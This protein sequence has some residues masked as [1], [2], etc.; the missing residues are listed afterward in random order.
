MPLFTPSFR[1]LAL[2]LFISYFSLLL[3]Q[4]EE[5]KVEILSLCC[6]LS[7]NFQGTIA[8]EIMGQVN[9]S[10]PPLFSSFWVPS[11]HRLTLSLNYKRKM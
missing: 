6:Y 7:E 5:R 3:Y 2:L 1:F 11:V 9:F 8:T 4:G 10:A